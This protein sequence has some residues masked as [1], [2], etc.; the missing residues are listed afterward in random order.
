[1][2]IRYFFKQILCFL[3]LHLLL[4]CI[5]NKKTKNVK[6]KNKKGITFD[7]IDKGHIKVTDQFDNNLGTYPTNNFLPSS[8]H[9]IELIKNKTGTGIVY[10]SFGLKG[11]MIPEFNQ[12]IKIIIKTLSTVSIIESAIRGCYELEKKKKEIDE[13]K[14]KIYALADKI[15]SSGED[16]EL[17]K[18][19]LYIKTHNDNL[20]KLEKISKREQKK[21]DQ[22]EILF[23]QAIKNRNK[24]LLQEGD[25]LCNKLLSPVQRNILQN[26]LKRTLENIRNNNKIDHDNQI[27]KEINQLGYLGKT[28]N[29][30]NVEQAIE[31]IK[32]ALEKTN[33]I[34]EKNIKKQ[35]YSKLRKHLKKVEEI[36]E[37]KKKNEIIKED[38]KKIKEINNLG[39]FGVNIG[40]KNAEEIERKISKAIDIAYGVKNIEI[41]NNLLKN[42]HQ[43]QTGIKQILE[44]IKK[45]KQIDINNK[46]IK[47]INELLNFGNSISKDKSEEAVNKIKEAI[48]LAENISNKKQSETIIKDLEKKIENITKHFNLGK[49]KYNKQDLSKVN[50]DIKELKKEYRKNNKLF[51]LVELN[52]ETEGELLVKNAKI[53]SKLKNLRTYRTR[54]RNDIGEKENDSSDDEELNSLE[55]NKKISEV[56]YKTVEFADTAITTASQLIKNPLIKTGIKTG[57][58]AA[59]Y[60]AKFCRNNLREK[61]NSKGINLNPPKDQKSIDEQFI[62]LKFNDSGNSHK[63]GKVRIDSKQ[64]N[65]IFRNKIGHLKDTPNNR[66]L[67]EKVGS[68]QKLRLGTDRYGSSWHAQINPNG[69]QIWVKVRNGQIVNGG[70]NKI[71]KSF[72]QETGL[73]ALKP[74]NSK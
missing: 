21:I 42:I 63:A 36:L 18:L 46:T 73:C 72:N 13:L 35:I 25:E 47:E 23:N 49:T 17:G 27:I 32:R 50:K 59:K 60:G 2:K 11:G 6:Y 64:T 19:E 26:S 5:Y 1:M 54:I 14:N 24:S 38:N 39:I 12:K 43:I 31:S 53:R 66:A 51:Q 70:V 67:L 68:N 71:P 28:I 52:K 37:N 69:S 45:H 65:H 29:E 30:K 9:N 48:Q 61:I 22:I 8:S 55:T 74:P 44:Q 62:N 15:N 57:I 10:T 34:L 58:K 41:R 56:V 20:A 40:L 3:T 7:F 4:S 33:L 16:D